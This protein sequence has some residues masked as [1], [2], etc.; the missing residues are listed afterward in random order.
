MVGGTWAR[1]YQ[2]GVGA[3]VIA[4]CVFDSEAT[5]VNTASPV[6]QFWSPLQSLDWNDKTSLVHELWTF[7]E[8]LPPAAIICLVICRGLSIEAPRRRCALRRPVS[9]LGSNS[10]PDCMFA[11]C[12][13]IDTPSESPPTAHSTSHRRCLRDKLKQ[14]RRL[15]FSSIQ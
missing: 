2:E 15:T 12:T 5:T 7:P 8:S 9:L 4:G 11:Y 6:L 3:V 14:T 1:V 13:N 10:S